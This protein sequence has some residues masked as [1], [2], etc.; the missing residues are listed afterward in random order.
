MGLIDCLKEENFEL[1]DAPFFYDEE[2]NKDN[3]AKKNL[4]AVTKLQAAYLKDLNSKSRK[5][6]SLYF[7]TENYE[8]LEP[9]QDSPN[10]RVTFETNAGN[11][12]FRQ[13]FLENVPEKETNEIFNIVGEKTI[14]SSNRYKFN[15]KGYP[16]GISLQDN[17][18]FPESDEEFGI[19]I[20]VHDS[21]I[22]VI[23]YR[24]FDDGSI[25]KHVIDRK[26][27]KKEGVYRGKKFENVYS[28]RGKRKDIE[29]FLFAS[30][31]KSVH[32]VREPDSRKEGVVYN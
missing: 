1:N 28:F 23:I 10:Y 32:A 18:S 25:G 8:G 24:E 22:P 29:N 16:A 13:K 21:K 14:E 26:K 20:E 4:P 12:K 2:G 7:N 30:N 9:T 15:S 31:I 17:F 6:P 3:P 11:Y 27:L 5:K 19:I